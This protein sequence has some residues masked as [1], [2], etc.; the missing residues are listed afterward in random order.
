MDEIKWMEWG[1][2]AFRRA[3]VED[4]P[5]LLSIGACW[6]HWC[7]V[8][9][10]TSYQDPEVIE[11][12]MRDFI[13]VRVDND[14]RPDINERYNM[15][16]WPTTAFLTPRG[17]LLAGGTYLP[18]EVMRRYLAEISRGYNLN[19]VEIYA[20]IL[21][22]FKDAPSPRPLERGA[23]LEEAIVERSL[24]FIKE[25]FDSRFGG[26]G[27]EPKFPQHGALSL[28]LYRWA[29]TGDGEL[30]RVLQATLDGMAGGGM[31]D[32]EAGGFF[33]YSTT[34]DW[35]VP[36]YEKMAEDNAALLK[37]YSEFFGLTGEEPYARTARE[38][39]G[40][41]LSALSDPEKAGFF[42]SQDADEDYYKLPLAERARLKAPYIDRA[43]YTNWNG[44][45]VSAFLTAG[46]ILR[47][48]SWQDFA[49]KSLNFLEAHCRAPEGGMYHYWDGEPHL[50]GLLSDQVYMAGALLDAYQ[51]EREPL[52]LRRAEE[53]ARYM[54]EAL[55]D[56]EGGGFLDRAVSAEELGYL[57]ED[58]KPL[59]LNADA[60]NVLL[61]LHYLTGE[62]SYRELAQKTLL[63]FRESFAA[64]SVMGAAYG[65][66]VERFLRPPLEMVV[67]GRRGEGGAEALWDEAFHYPRPGKLI[68]FLDQERDREAISRKGLP[69]DRGPALYFCAGHTCSAPIR[70]PGHLESALKGFA[71]GQAG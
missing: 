28:C 32:R 37:I 33:R 42:G 30:F 47:E 67:V 19:K 69:L 55:F 48:P 44:Q 46:A 3:A 24:G 17:D 18:P 63:A 59:P 54:K 40:Y 8:M 31:Y 65:L 34:R 1:E 71:G 2:E 68:Q 38:V 6:C 41:I 21:K 43:I 49:L 35:S 25:T 5:I 70:E 15:G 7:H 62:E 56:E 51:A 57:K 64:H 4:K 60:A 29:R 11:R 9:D 26:F 27:T 66:A 23:S 20:E 39:A 22:R 13:P 58:R 50:R 45:M 53:L 14:K 12:V 61:D 52:Y 36:H 10:G 16:G